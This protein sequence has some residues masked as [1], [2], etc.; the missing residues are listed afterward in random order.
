MP[1]V[2]TKP[3]SPGRRHVVKVYHP[4]LHKGR[5]YAPLVEKK[6]KSGGRNNNGRITTRH[7]GGGHKQQYR[8]VD[9]K[10]NKD[11]IPSVV[12][13]IEYDPNRS[14]HIALLKYLDG[15]RRYIIAP[16]GV[17]AG[18]EV[19]SGEDA[20]IKVG[21]TLPMRNIPVGS[22][23]HCI[24]LKPGKGAQ[25]A[26]SAGTY[27][28]L[29]AREGA[30]ATLRLRSGEMRKVLSEC[31]ATLGEV[32]NSEHSLRQLGKAGASRWRGVR[33]TVRGVVMNPVDHPHGGGEGR[34]SGGRHPVTPWG[35]PTKG[36]K[37]RKNKRTDK[38]I[39][40]RRSAK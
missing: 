1:V 3:T 22:V 7:I 19:R 11:G 15:E 28:Q 30:Y 5:P 23:I 16:K 24:E 18:D 8:I 40:R 34:T 20:P 25:I 33:P 10:R 36:H 38:M 37:T 26:R 39:V 32:S 27:A 35:V 2:K 14:A 9:F 21:S 17:K 12:E 13:R 31:R 4:D 29:V 6:S